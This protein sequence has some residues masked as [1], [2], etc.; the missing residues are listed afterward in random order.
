MATRTFLQLCQRL[1]T[2][3]G[4]TG[5]MTNTE[6][7]VGEFKRVVDWVAEA[8]EEIEGMWFNWNFLHQFHTFPTIAGVKDYPPPPN[9]NLWDRDTFSIQEY[10]SPLDYVEW[11]RQKID[12][13]APVLGDPYKVTALPSKALRLYDTPSLIVTI[14]AQYWASPTVLVKSGDEPAIPE[15]FRRVIIYKALQY[16]ADYE[17]AD[18]TLQLSKAMFAP[19]MQQLESSELPANQASGSINTGTHVQVVG[20]SDMS[21][22]DY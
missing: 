16:Y 4:I 7:Q 13:T 12:P 1:I 19:A 17:S 3:A 11:T 14:R 15:S 8:T 20:M 5:T 9:L 2:K 22:Y 21:G 18:E 6:N 10:E